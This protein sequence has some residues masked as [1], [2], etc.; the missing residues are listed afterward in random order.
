MKVTPKQVDAAV[1]NVLHWLHRDQD[2]YYE[3]ENRDND[4][5]IKIDGW[6]SLRHIV[7]EALEGGL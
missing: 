6:V 2:T 1:K 7:V 5:L 3:I 4:V